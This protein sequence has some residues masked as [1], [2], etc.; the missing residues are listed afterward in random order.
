MLQDRSRV[1]KMS[2][3][4]QARNESDA[5][6]KWRST[7]ADDSETLSNRARKRKWRTAEVET[8]TLATR[9]T[10]AANHS[11][12]RSL[13]LPVERHTKEISDNNNSPK[14]SAASF[15]I[16][17]KLIFFSKQLWQ[18]LSIGLMIILFKYYNVLRFKECTVKN[19]KYNWNIYHFLHRHCCQAWM[20]NQ[21]NQNFIQHIRNTN[22]L[23]MTSFSYVA[24]MKNNL[25][26]SCEI[27]SN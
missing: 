5:A 15:L 8:Q 7:D 13:E 3:E 22:C 26:N 23:A 16:L 18:R 25:Q 20:G 24:R 17:S 6:R 10:D 14:R 11:R 1:S 19:E 27:W 21:L 4:V 12:T 9:E 2:E